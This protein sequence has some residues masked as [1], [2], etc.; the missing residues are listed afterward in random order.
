MI[1][2]NRRTGVVA[3]ISRALGLV[4]RR[5]TAILALVVLAQGT[6]ALLD[7][8]GILM[9]GLVAAVGT[10]AIQGTS[11]QVPGLAILA[12]L[13]F[14]TSDPVRLVTV[15]ALVAAAALLV[16]S[17]ASA[18]LTRKVLL[19]LARRQK[20]V[21]GRLTAMLLQ[22]SLVDVQS[23][24]SHQVAYAIGPGMN[25]A[26]VVLIGQ[27]VMA[28]SEVLLLAALTLLLFFVNPVVAIAALA[29]F[30]GLGILMQTSLGRWSAGLG[31]VAAD[32]EVA[33]TQAIHEAMEAFREIVVT[34]RT[35]HYEG[36]IRELRARAA[37]VL[38]RAQFL[39]QIPKY[40]LEVALVVG[41]ALLAA[42][43]LFAED[44]TGAAATLAVFLVAGTRML[45]ALMRMQGAV[46]QIREA[47]GR[48]TPTFDLADFLQSRLDGRAQA[49]P[50]TVESGTHE[51]A[52]HEE[53]R[54]F[55]PDI[56]VEGV[57]FT[58]P[59]AD[60]PTLRDVSF[61]V[62]AGA[63]LALVGRSGAGKSTLAD[64]IL[65]V[66]E[67]SQGSVWLGGSRSRDAIA[68]WPGAVSYVPQDVMLANATIRENVALGLPLEAIDENL[69]WEALGRAHLEDFVRHLPSGLD[70][71]IGERGTRLSGG[72]RQRLGLA[73]AF[74]SRPSV[75]VMDEATSALD[76]ETE[77][78][79]ALSVAEL[80]GS[81]TTVTI[82]HRLATVRNVDQV[83]FL[84]DGVQAGTGTFDEIR[85]RFPDFDRQARLLGL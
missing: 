45:P 68:R 18:L 71:E 36:R 73:R 6:L 47:A 21:S 37:F 14:D 81:V 41:A 2:P 75:L 39:G 24:S 42:Y 53:R 35:K 61:Y 83:V 44:K 15:L 49:L 25:L 55:T 69:V 3:D 16:K 4:G 31:G 60:S 80:A 19:F 38:G 85:E 9:L 40:V 22:S 57:F 62:P 27:A 56:R 79:I 23:L 46:L 20:E 5:D 51:P 84:R 48:A 63:S 7:L 28:L 67:P 54:P 52:H 43:G 78:L 12:R 58:Y 66:L 29:Y 33:S 8:F 11:G 74:Y 17:V 10:S 65:G 82:A 59:G 34:G 26:T 13:G 70:T 1:R 32:T 64:L 76:A 30:L 77:Q 72:Q 50:R